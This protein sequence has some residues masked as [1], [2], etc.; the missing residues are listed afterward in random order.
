MRNN[1]EV[2]IIEKKGGKMG[3]R[4]REGII[5][6]TEHE[7]IKSFEALEW[8]FETTTSWIAT[9]VVLWPI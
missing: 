8:T 2:V 7:S 3:R 1:R 5:N 4:W 6:V 9:F